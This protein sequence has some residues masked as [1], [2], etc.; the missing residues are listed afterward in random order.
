MVFTKASGI[1]GLEPPQVKIGDY[2]FKSQHINKYT[3]IEQSNAPI[4]QSFTTPARKWTGM[5]FYCLL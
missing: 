2:P 3:L 5:L 1:R 4:E